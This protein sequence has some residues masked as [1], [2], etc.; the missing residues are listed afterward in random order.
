MSK[1][2]HYQDVNSSASLSTASTTTTKNQCWILVDNTGLPQHHWRLLNNKD[3]PCRTC[4]VTYSPDRPDS[5]ASYTLTGYANTN[6]QDVANGQT[7]RVITTNPTAQNV[8]D[9][10]PTYFIQSG[11]G[12]GKMIDV[13]KP[14]TVPPPA[15]TTSSQWNT[16][17]VP[18][19]HHRNQ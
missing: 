4:I 9:S 10:Y 11:K 16:R 14:F 2:S 15:R 13:R 18:Q 1:I 5:H 17:K 19:Q 6:A 7:M 12:D 3:I 8:H